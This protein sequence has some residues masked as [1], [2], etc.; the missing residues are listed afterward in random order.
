MKRSL[1]VVLV[2]L[3]FLV[4]PAHATTGTTDAAAFGIELCPQSICG[5]AIFT[6]ILSGEVA[7]ISTSLGS[8]AVSVT[9]DDLPVDVG[10]QSAITGGS[11]QLRAGVRTF[12]GVILGGT[13]TYLGSNRFAV[14]MDL[15]S[16]TAGAL[17]F[18]G[19][20]DHTPF[21][22]TIVGTIVSN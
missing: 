2:L 10:Q 21:P 17:A 1:A 5:S 9:H 4:T 14:D 8:F 6:G 19:I 3:A 22:P 13:L 7:G 12:R 16:N 15:A 20:L 11:F 18:S